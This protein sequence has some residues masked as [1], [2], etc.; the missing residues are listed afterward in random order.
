MLDASGRKGATTGLIVPE[1][2]SPHAR[3]LLDG[4]PAR[5]EL[6]FFHCVRQQG[7]TAALQSSSRGMEMEVSLCFSSLG[8]HKHGSG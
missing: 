5:L 8:V 6:A 1:V 2:A 7:C 4:M 3:N